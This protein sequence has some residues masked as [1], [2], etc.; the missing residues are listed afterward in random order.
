MAM[1]NGIVV[2]LLLVTAGWSASAHARQVTAAGCDRDC[3]RGAV[4][5]RLTEDAV[6]KPLA[7]VG[8]VATVTALRDFRQDIIDERAG[9]AGAHVVFEENGAPVLLVVRVKVVA[10]SLTEIELVATRNATEGLI[11]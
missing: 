4:T 6:E 3:L 10:G 8:L 11:F 2:G 5:Q 7:K 9:V 1:R